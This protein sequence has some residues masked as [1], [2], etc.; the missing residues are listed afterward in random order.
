[1]EVS[2]QFYTVIKFYKK[3]ESLETGAWNGNDPFS[4]AKYFSSSI[5][6]FLGKALI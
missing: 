3:M 5:N 2:F 1:M 4:K 6:P